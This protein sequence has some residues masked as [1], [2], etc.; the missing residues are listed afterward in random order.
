MTLSEITQKISDIQQL[1][2]MDQEA[3]LSQNKALFI[4]LVQQDEAYLI[5]SPSGQ[6]F[7][8]PVQEDDPRLFLRVFS[9]EEAAQSFAE[10]EPGRE[11][12]PI[13]GVELMQA[14]KT[15]F[16][17]GVYG[18]LLNDGLAWAVLSFPDFLAECFRTILG[19]E[20]MAGE[21]FT[22]LVRLINMVRQNDHYKI[23]LAEVPGEGTFFLD[24]AARQAG[25]LENCESLDVQKLLRFLDLP[26]NAPI[27]VKMDGVDYEMTVDMLQGA[28]RVTGLATGEEWVPLDFYTDFISLDF[29]P[30]DF[31]REEI[32]APPVEEPPA[33]EKKP[34]FLSRLKKEKAPKPPKEKKSKKEKVS[35]DTQEPKT[36]SPERKR[37]DSRS[38]VLG[39]AT[40]FALA[41][42]LIC[43]VVFY[44]HFTST[45]PLDSL[46]TDIS[47]Q[48]YSSL[49]KHYDGCLEEGTGEEALLLMS[50]DLETWVQSYASESCTAEELK[51]IISIYASIG[52]M[53]EAAENAYTRAAIMEQ[54]KKAYQEGLAASSISGRLECWRGVSMEDASSYGA[55][56]SNLSEHAVEYKYII[57]TEAASLSESE[58]LSRLILLQSFYPGDTDIAARIRAVQAGDEPITPPDSETP[59]VPNEPTQTTQYISISR[60]AVHSGGWNGE[61]DLYIDWRNISGKQIDEVDFEVVP[62]NQ[63]GEQASTK[64]ADAN[65]EFYSRYLARDVGPFEDG[66]V[67]PSQHLWSDAWVNGTISSVT[68]DKVSI[69]FSG[70]EN[71]VIITDANAISALF[72]AK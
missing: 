72:A 15:C 36:P 60:A 56:L 39:I 51:D 67:T 6:L 45:S 55:M 13:D 9:H 16:L 31:A 2:A 11:V 41:A 8:A 57:F 10:K 65:G 7:A 37:R 49:T 23:V 30:E 22:V 5:R 64:I 17:R 71:P 61:I 43:A 12:L 59:D 1:A 28:I 26:G 38:I 66:Y 48:Y 69:F 21:E 32:P 46:K 18:F 24:E 68:I 19:N 33:K 52:D 40:M 20:N 70:E 14:A 44:V 62:Y 63:A 47:T 27:C 53:Q 3:A 34:G 25:A 4:S 35:P 58:A 42:A 54:S 50:E 29:R